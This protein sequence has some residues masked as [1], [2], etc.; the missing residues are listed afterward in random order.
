VPLPDGELVLAR[1]VLAPVKADVFAFQRLTIGVGIDS[2]EYYELLTFVRNEVEVKL[3][4]RLAEGAGP[5][6]LD[7]IFDRTAV[8]SA[9]RDQPRVAIG[10][11]ELVFYGDRC[12]LQ[13]LRTW[14]GRTVQVLIRMNRST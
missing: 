6:P 11:L 1:G 5:T 3:S 9:A 10:G 12:L 7:T 8:L 13:Q 2:S 14:H 4:V